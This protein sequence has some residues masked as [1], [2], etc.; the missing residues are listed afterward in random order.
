M[1]YALL[2]VSWGADVVNTRSGPNL[3]P[4]RLARGVNHA[5]INDSIPS[6]Y[7]H[8]RSSHYKRSNFAVTQLE[9]L[10]I[11]DIGQEPISQFVDIYTYHE[12]LPGHLRTPVHLVRLPFAQSHSQC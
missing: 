1:A 3:M 8:V 7:R 10:A 12:A 9:L 5:L 11:A 4:D 2:A 6:L